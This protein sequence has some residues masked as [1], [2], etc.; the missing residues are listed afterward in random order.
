MAP[1]QGP[2][3][4]RRAPGF[5]QLDPAAVRVLGALIEKE[6]A[7]PDYYP[8]SLNALVNACNQKSNRDPVVSLD[9]TEVTGALNVLEELA[10]VRRV[11]GEGRAVKH[12]HRAYETLNLGNREAAVLC[13]LLLRG[14]QTPGEL[15]SRTQSLYA[16]DDLEAVEACA[17]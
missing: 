13:V 3:A 9:E 4:V 6:M 17:A 8:L 5:V 14:P 10:L 2:G 1:G 12:A 16:F 7:T 15:R 11:T